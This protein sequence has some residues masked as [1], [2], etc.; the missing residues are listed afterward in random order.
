MV[1]VYGPKTSTTGIRYTQQVWDQS[2]VGTKKVIIL[3]VA[4]NI[5]RKN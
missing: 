3:M 4:E 5:M 1:C 2:Y